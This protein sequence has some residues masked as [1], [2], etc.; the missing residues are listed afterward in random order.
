VSSEADAGGRPSRRRVRALL[1]ILLPVLLLAGGGWYWQR[2]LLPGS[3][4]VMDMGH[5]DY[6][7]GPVP[8]SEVMG[9]SEEGHAIA[10]MAGGTSVATLVGPSSPADVSV[11]LTARKAKV[12]LG[13]EIPRVVDGYTLNVTSPGPQITARVGQL[14]E[15]RLNNDNVD[16]GVALHWHGVDV[17]NGEDGVA[18]VTQD[19]VRKGG[20]FT[21]RFVVKDAG[22][23]WYH[24][25]QVADEQVKGGMYGALVVLPVEPPKQTDAVAL[26]HSYDGYRTINA[27]TGTIHVDAKP[28][29][30]VRVRIVNT[31][32]GPLQTWVAGSDY[33]LLAIDGRD[34]HEPG[35]VSNKTVVLAAGARADLLVTAPPDGSDATVDMG[36]GSRLAVGP[37]GGRI[38]TADDPG[39]DLDELTYGTP[40]TMS[41]DPTRPTRRF[42]YAIGRR[43]G[44]FDG[45]PGF[46]WTID[47]HQFPD[48]SVF[49]VQEGDVVQ[50]T[51][52]NSSGSV[53]PMHLHG[54]HA[55]VLSRNG[56]PSTG[57][58]WI[59]DSLNVENGQ[60]YVIAFVADNPGIWMDHCHNLPHAS[61]GLVT[62]LMYAGVTT[63][64]MVGGDAHND[65]E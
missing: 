8:A 56:R 35:D 42:T 14:V 47:G 29:Q 33:R 3:Y 22:T 1:G 39:T 26:V 63:P 64:Y 53:H 4:S 17:A 36:A 7:G 5:P 50:M 45:K 52:R 65:P 62:H 40:T 25:H 34:V 58:P 55:V 28:G 46:W 60:T 24:S 37:A 20:S 30:Q 23:Y 11:T 10:G 38:V 57:S 18:G 59:V 12:Q 61:Q 41:F 27:A 31:D 9:Q 13:G 19:A 6:G 49:V 2:S 43:I 16:A 44:L 51:I 54:H 32:D 15:V 21:Y 48:V